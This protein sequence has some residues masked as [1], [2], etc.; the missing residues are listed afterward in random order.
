MLDSARADGRVHETTVRFSDELWMQV[1]HV[2]RRNGTS[3]AQFV[4]EATLARLAV[5][6]HISM[7]RREVAI[8]LHRL[9]VRLRRIE[10]RLRWHGVR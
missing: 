7:L 8:D 3:A 2:S 5:E 10:E 6:P 1:Q 9:D 4:R